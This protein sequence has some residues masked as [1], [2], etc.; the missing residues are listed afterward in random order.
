MTTLISY[1]TRRAAGSA[2]LDVY[3][4]TAVALRRQAARDGKTLRNLCGGL[5]A[6]AGA[7]VIALVLAA[8]STPAAR[9]LPAMAQAE[10]PHIW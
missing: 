5:L 4:A 3:R 9:G 1:D 10:T 6:L 8:G 7:A 2:D